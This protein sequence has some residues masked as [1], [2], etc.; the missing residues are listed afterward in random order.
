[1]NRVF[2]MCQK[3][4]E[5]NTNIRDRETIDL[6][7][8]SIM[9]IVID[10]GQSALDLIPEIL[11]KTNIISDNRSV[12][13]VEHQELNNYKED[14]QL[15]NAKAC[16]TR[17]FS[18]EG[19][20]CFEKR[21]LIIPKNSIKTAP[22]NTVEQIIHE[23]M[24]LLRFRNAVRDNDKIIFN[25]GLATKTIDLNSHITYR[26]NYMLEEAANQHFAKRA[27][28]SLLSYS[29]EITVTPLFTRINHDKPEYKSKIYDIYV[30]LFE[31]FMEDLNLNDLIE[32]T[33]I[34]SSLPVER[35][36]N[37]VMG[38]KEAFI[39]L[40]H[41]FNKLEQLL[42]NNQIDDAKKIIACIL[43]DYNTFKNNT[44]YGTK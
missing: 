34:S 10:R 41:Y 30:K 18:F 5:I 22:I 4:V 26:K 23:L 15:V 21:Y 17:L 38:D 8:A 1:M 44:S 27:L 11:R 12:L 40:S 25:E 35:Y 31:K 24:H 36:F 42:N 43:H 20:K 33:F 29:D 14:K 37:T 7:A 13:E 28:N 39:K 16:V 3:I 6:L 9:G 2:I 19:D 32:H